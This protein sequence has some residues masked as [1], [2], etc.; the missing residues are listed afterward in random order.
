[1]N[2]QKR[3]LFLM[4]IA[5]VQIMISSFFIGIT[6]AAGGTGHGFTVPSDVT[7][8]LLLEVSG[9]VSGESG[10]PLPGVN[11]LVK[12]TT[13]GTTTD[14][15]GAYRLEVENSG[16]VLVFSFIGYVTQEVSV[17]NRTSI[18]IALVE[19]IQALNEVVVVG[20]GTQKKSDVTGS[21]ARVETSKT[22]DL[23]NYN[24]LQSLQGRVPGLNVTTPDRPGEDP[25][26]SVRGTNSISAGNSPLVVVDGII[27]NG[28][29]SD[30]NANDIA[31][32]DILKDAS[33]AAVYGSRAAN[34]VLLIT[35]KSGTSE[36]PQF[37]FT[38]Y[39]GVQ[40]PDRLIDIQHGPGY[41]QKVLDFREAT[42]QEA[43]PA[44]I[45][46]YLT[47]VEAENRRNG[48][49]T[50]WMDH[51][52]RTGVI[53]NYHLDV[54]GKTDKTNY[55]IAG[56]Y[57]KQEGI[58]K[59]DDFDRV[60]VNLN[61]TNHITDWYS[62][63]VKSM[64]SSQDRS[65]REAS[66]TN[67]YR[68]SPYGN[69]YDPD[70]PGG[71]AF[72]PVGDPLGQHPLINTLIDDKD[73]R[74]SLWGLFS[75]N[76]EVPF[77][78]GLKWTL[79]ASANLRG[80]DIYQF[81]DNEST[82]NGQVENGIGTK[83]QREY[84]DWTVDNIV[85]YRKVFNNVHSL[86]LTLLYSRERQQFTSSYM[87]ANNFFTQAL[88]YNNL[89][90]AQV[91]E[92]DSDFEDQNS[93]AYMGRI[94][95]GYDDR[96][97]ITLTARRD[98]FSGFSES[99][100]YAT[101]PSVALAWTASNEEF[102]NNVA[103]LKYLKLRL[104]YGKNGNQAVGRYQSLARM[105]SD[106]YV[107]GSTPFTT[108]YANSMANNQLGWETTTTTNLGFDYS[109][110]DGKI[111]GSVDVYSSDTRDL[112]LGKA[113][114][115]SSGYNSVLT[116]VGQV[117]N[118]GVELSLN[119][120]NVTNENLSWESGFVFTLNRN[121]VEKLTGKDADGDGN[122][123]D[124]IGNAWF[125]GESLHSIYG[126]QIDGI[127]QL[128]DTDIPPGFE[129]GE[130]RIVDTDGDNEI[131]PDDRIILGNR[132]PNYSFSIANTVRFK[133]FTFY[134]LINAIQ[135][136]NNYYMAN[137][138]ASRNV[139]APF[140]T[141]TERF[142]V[143]DVPY[144]TP[145]RPSNE[146]PKINYN[147]SLPHPIL[148]DRSFVRIQD[149]SLSYTFDKLLLDRLKVRGLRLYASAKNLHTFTKWTGYDPE[150][151]TT[152]NNFPLL[153]TYTLGIDFKF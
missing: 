98:G 24:I 48:V 152:L 37:N 9:T 130:F 91:Q 87:R 153:R 118:Q 11:I 50:D 115:E 54:S 134:M 105:N 22:A 53:N 69:F 100:K 43:D 94:N 121:R 109:I 132:L 151:A 16:A 107:F 113:L 112:L 75:S 29:F 124:D 103:W 62:V 10:E 129:P 138:N 32:V 19:D 111:S 31:T 84:F 6:Y 117:H 45:D 82:T 114:P 146:Y 101:F 108:V 47:P 23:P 28:S 90:L 26:I 7:L 51:V 89:G 133:N 95:Y 34:G 25:G 58:V 40:T 52:I 120:L 86:D 143:Q 77:V 149:V 4:K 97:A 150:N 76:L 30:F 140:T 15:N 57:F 17:G 126:Y 36:K 1:M 21:V 137:N 119:S 61:L 93:L 66:L 64:F 33:A 35:T 12:G 13:T 106:Q 20:Y 71:Y 41:L 79:N 147:A 38:S 92:V 128:D 110:Y 5:I 60:T 72:M 102:M 99:H 73:V 55:Y 145:T 88:G 18:N 74:N 104:S 68:Q 78:P 49:T 3:W 96:Y 136:G 46:D 8:S 80:L 142:N 44:R 116:N 39:Y 27:Y 42:G 81:L 63:T 135:G 59:N 56:T 14:T 125:I 2:K 127:Y 123:D 144:W 70:G 141:F 85:N 139:N 131:T 67:A 148:E 83:D 65:G 122:E